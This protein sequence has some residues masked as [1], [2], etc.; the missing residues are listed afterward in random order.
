MEVMFG[1]LYR[2]HLSGLGNYPSWTGYR[3]GREDTKI[4]VNHKFDDN[5]GVQ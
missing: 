2:K 5:K 3:H 1:E 4:N